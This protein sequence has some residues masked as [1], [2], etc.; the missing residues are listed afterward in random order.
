M[1]ESKNTNINEQQKKIPLIVQYHQQLDNFKKQ[2]DQIK[3]QLDQIQG[4]IFA[5]E[6]MINQYE[7]YLKQEAKELVSNQGE[8]QNGKINITEKEKASKE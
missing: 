6:L 4:T 5:C 3:I 7:S 8:N 1:S 2:R